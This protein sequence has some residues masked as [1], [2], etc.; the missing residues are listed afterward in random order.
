MRSFTDIFRDHCKFDNRGIH[1]GGTDRQSNHNYGAA[2]DALFPPHVRESVRL[3]L[4][5]GNADGMGLLSLAEA[6]PLANLVGLDIHP[7]A[8]R[9]PRVETNLGDATRQ[10][11]CERV[12]AGVG[13]IGRKFDV[14]IDDATHHLADALRTLLFLWPHVARGGT[15]IIEELEG[16]ASLRRNLSALLPDIQI[17]DTDGPFGGIEPLVVLRRMYGRCPLRPGGEQCALEAGHEG[18]C[19]WE[20][21]D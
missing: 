2:Y 19:K 11:D 8:N 18:G 12:A 3:V 1:V 15:Y 9:H 10:E 4:E 13:G 20:R 17:V 6:F 5:V 21:G 14:V 7:V 16:I